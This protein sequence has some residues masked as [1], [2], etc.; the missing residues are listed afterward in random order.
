MTGPVRRRLALAL[1][2][3]VPAAAGVVLA[4]RAAGGA[5]ERAERRLLRSEASIAAALHG[6]AAAAGDPVAAL[7]A[8]FGNRWRRT[9][10][11][12][13]LLDR[14]EVAEADGRRTARTTLFGPDGWT[15]VGTLELRAPAGRGGGIPW[16]VR[17]GAGLGLLLLLAALA[18]LC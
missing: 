2:A 14:P 4:L 17:I 9:G 1:A 16:P 15:R 7:D 5:V 3:F 12:D 11:V 18:A 10:R 6:E 13:S 8:V